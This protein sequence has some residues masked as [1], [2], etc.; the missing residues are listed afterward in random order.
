MPGFP[1]E[2]HP[3]EGHP[4]EG[5]PLE[6]RPLAGNP[7]PGYPGS[8]PA[9]GE[10][11]A[12]GH[13][14]TGPLPAVGPWIPAG[15]ENILRDY[16]DAED[17]PASTAVRRL[18]VLDGGRAGAPDRPADDAHWAML[19]YLTVPFFGFL[20]PVVVYLVA[21]RRSRWLRQHAAQAFNVWLTWLLYN[22]SAVIAGGVLMLDSPPVALVIVV[23]LIVALWLVTLA[24]LVRAAAAASRGETYTVPRW[25][26]TIVVR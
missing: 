5:R 24:F 15:A 18:T 12:H 6:G 20:V 19:G 10:F 23:P 1:L 22:L 2:G 21:L 7:V 25:L 9:A 13:P 16:T 14:G 17:G 4:L 26:C 11:G 3:L 8:G